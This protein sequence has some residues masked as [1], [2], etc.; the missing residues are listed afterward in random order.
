MA[1]VHKAVCEARGQ[2]RCGL[3]AGEQKPYLEL[4]H[5]FRPTGQSEHEFYKEVR[6]TIFVADGDMYLRYT[7]N[8]AAFPHRAVNVFH[9]DATEDDNNTIFQEFMSHPIMLLEASFCRELRFFLQGFPAEQRRHEFERTMRLW[10]DRTRA[11][12][13]NEEKW[14]AF[15]RIDAT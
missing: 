3:R 2:L 12:S 4:M 15:Q 10:M 6:A 13:L 1:D 9:P 5:A 11:A 7:L 14:H 8:H